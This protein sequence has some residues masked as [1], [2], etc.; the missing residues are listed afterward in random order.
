M[1]DQMHL[2]H[3]SAAR[4]GFCRLCT[5][6]GTVRISSENRGISDRI[7]NPAATTYPI[8]RLVARAAAG[9]LT[10]E[11]LGEM[12]PPPITAERITPRTIGEQ[13]ARQSARC[14]DRATKTGVALVF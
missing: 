10:L 8:V 13:T 3:S 14:A 5:G 12:P 6:W 9:R 11:P 2:H 4:G 7:T 1:V